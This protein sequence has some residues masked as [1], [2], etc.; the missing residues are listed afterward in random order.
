MHL[1]FSALGL[2]TLAWRSCVWQGGCVYLSTGRDRGVR[3]AVGA[4]LEGDCCSKC[5][6]CWECAWLG[7]RPLWWR[8]APLKRVGAFGLSHTVWTGRSLKRVG[9]GRCSDVDFSAARW[10]IGTIRGASRASRHHSSSPHTSCARV[11][12]S[13]PNSVRLTSAHWAVSYLAAIW[14]RAFERATVA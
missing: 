12:A 10:R 6:G 11:H 9:R 4:D 14:G 13:V 2:L 7:G 1:R 5:V 8:A 3:V